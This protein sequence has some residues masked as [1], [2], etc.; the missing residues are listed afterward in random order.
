[1][2][3]ALKGKRGPHFPIAADAPKSIRKEIERR[4]DLVKDIKFEPKLFTEEL[5][6]KDQQVYPHVYRMKAVDTL[7][8][9]EEAIVTS[10][11]DTSKR[12]PFGQDVKFYLQSLI[13][14]GDPLESVDPKTIDAFV[15][16]YIHAKHEPL[17]LFGVN[18]YNKHVELVNEIIA[19]I[20]KLESSSQ[21]QLQKIISKNPIIATSF[22]ITGDSSKEKDSVFV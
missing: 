6:E 22:H 11:G 12:K 21:S 18:E 16:S 1:M 13:Q 8:D 14:P 4:I 9:I 10:T 7:K 17:P 5:N 20:T 19:S 15:E 2:R 3:F